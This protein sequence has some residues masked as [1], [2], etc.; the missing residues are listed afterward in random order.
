MF[1]IFGGS[2]KE[3]RPQFNRPSFSLTSRSIRR[4]IA[5]NRKSFLKGFDIIRFELLDILKIE[6]KQK[7]DCI[8][9]RFSVRGF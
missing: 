8:F 9:K 7:Q 4:Y 3:G 2:G 6:L 1:H 5:L